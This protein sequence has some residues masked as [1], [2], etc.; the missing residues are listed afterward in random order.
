MKAI[1]KKTNLAMIF[2]A[3][4][5]V[6]ALAAAGMLSP[7]GEAARAARIV[8]ESRGAGLVSGDAPVVIAGDA[9]RIAKALQVPKKLFSRTSAQPRFR[10]A[11]VPGLSI[12]DET[13]APQSSFVSR[14]NNWNRKHPVASILIPL[15]MGA[16]V[17]VGVTGSPLGA[18][19]GLIGGTAALIKVI[20]LKRTAR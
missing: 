17:G 12:K 15:A 19:I 6:P 5:F 7:E 14:L 16:A 3:G 9:A 2:L 13:A 4:S 10:T 1:F 20:V 8:G 11:K 18:L